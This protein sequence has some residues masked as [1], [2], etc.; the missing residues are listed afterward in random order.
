MLIIEEL[1]IDPDVLNDTTV[2]A[3]DETLW[4]NELCN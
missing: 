1:R 2:I 4:L 3:E